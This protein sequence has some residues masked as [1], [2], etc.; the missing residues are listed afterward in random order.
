MVERAVGVIGSSSLVG[1]YL[2]P[3]LA[4]AGWTPVP[5][6][7]GRLAAAGEGGAIAHWV[8]LAPVWTV[9]EQ[10]AL[11]EAC[12]A[13]RVVALSSTS[14]DSKAG[15]REAADQSLVARL[16]MGEA[17]LAAWGA[18]QGVQWVLLRPTLIYG[19]GRD[20]NV[21]DIARLIR[22]FGWFPLAGGGAGLRQP[23]HAEDVAAA[24]V[25]ALSAPQAAGGTYALSGGETLSYRDLV[26]RVFQALGRP[27]RLF[28]LPSWTV[29]TLL[30]LLR[31]LPRFR[32]WTPAMAERMNADL[33]FDHGAAARDLGFTPRPFH[34]RGEDLP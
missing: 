12:G 21:S 23:V 2:L 17:A 1:D 16:R 14:V 9:T 19:G 28:A 18:R 32:H 4:A 33:V 8:L 11:W 27:V 31:L 15:S 3:Q 20:R 5:W 7:R 30:V 10:L 26:T 24:C 34:P 22:R 6:A 25:A 29:R 13:R